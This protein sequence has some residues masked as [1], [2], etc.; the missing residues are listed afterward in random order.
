MSI[1]T[2]LDLYF[3]MGPSMSENQLKESQSRVASH[4]P[5]RWGMG[6][7][8]ICLD[9]KLIKTFFSC[10]FQFPSSFFNIMI[11]P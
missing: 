2:S 11:A 1:S 9:L 6:R 10:L 3:E 7:H 4:H 5:P 8:I